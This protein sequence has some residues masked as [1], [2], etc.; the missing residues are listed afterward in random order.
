MGAFD[1]LMDLSLLIA[2]VLGISALGLTQDMTYPFLIAIIPAVVALA[3]S[4][5]WL[6]ETRT[7]I[8]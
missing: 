7:S 5:G 6:R 1:S 3:C 2:P 8:A 4:I